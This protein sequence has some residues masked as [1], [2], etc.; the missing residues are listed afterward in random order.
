MDTMSK[1][2]IDNTLFIDNKNGPNL[3]VAESWN[4][5]IDFM[6]EKNAD[7]LIIMGASMRF[8]KHGGLDMI[9]ELEHRLSANIVRF[10]SKDVPIQQFNNENKAR[11]PIFPEAFYWHCT[12]ISKDV[13]EQVGYFDPN[14]YPIYFEDT[15]YD[16]RIKKVGYKATDIIVPID[17]TDLGAGHGVQLGG[18]EAAS[19]PLVAYFAT[20]WGRHPSARGI[21][22]YQYPFDE[23]YNSVKYFPPTHGRTCD[24]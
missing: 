17:A 3:G 12:A 16:L 6:K 4:R 5:G 18:V 22:E 21:G 14:F 2:L 1:Q 23:V 20:K 8:G 7:W 15:D 10:A 19:S 13:V 24:E 11:N 9:Q